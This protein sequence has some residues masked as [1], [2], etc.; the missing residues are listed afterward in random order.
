MSTARCSKWSRTAVSAVVLAV[1]VPLLALADSPPSPSRSELD[2]ANTIEQGAPLSPEVVKD[3]AKTIW[4]AVEILED[5]H[6]KKASRQQLI[7]WAVRGL[8][9]RLGEKLP[10][11]IAYRLETIQ[12]LNKAELK[13][14]LADARAYLGKRRYLED[15]RDIDLVLAGTFSNLEPG[16]QHPPQ[17]E[18]GHKFYFGGSCPVPIGLETV[19]DAASGVL[20]AVT[21]LRGSPAHL[22]GI[23]AGDRITRMY[24]LDRERR[25]GEQTIFSG[26][27]LAARPTLLDGQPGSRIRLLVRREGVKQPLVF[28]LRRERIVPETVFG[29]CRKSDGSWDHLLDNEQKIGYVRLTSIG[30]D[31]PRDFGVALGDLQKQGLKGLILDLRFS[32]GGLL[33]AAESVAAQLV[34]KGPFCLIRTRDD[35]ERCELAQGP[36]LPP[37]VPVV[38]LVDGKTRFGSELIAACLQDRGRALIIG[39]RTLGETTIRNC[40]SLHG[41][42][43]VF[44]VGVFDRANGRNLSRMMTNGGEEEEWGVRPSKGFEVKLSRSERETLVRRLH[45]QRIIPLPGRSV[46]VTTDD[47]S[48]RQLNAALDC[49]RKQPRKPD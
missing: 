42:E 23:R 5:G 40:T 14:L 19:P 47:F 21:P 1:F 17:R 7:E 22:A 44:T 6:I 30:R 18:L 49:L 33:T 45:D 36:N 11:A 25:K 16:Y 31:T 38:C 28:N 10:P 41:A 20:Q 3:F 27:E 9:A 26:D 24:E 32:P 4:Q 29:V 8:Y 39:E 2:N 43:L 12:T 35:S 46:P 48:D 37:S 13:K 34:G 15:Q